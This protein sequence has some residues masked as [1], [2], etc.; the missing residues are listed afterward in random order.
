LFL[1][2]F[3]LEVS[4]E[5][6]TRERE[7]VLAVFEAARGKISNQFFT[8]RTNLHLRKI[9]ILPTRTNFPVAVDFKNGR[10]EIRQRHKDAAQCLREPGSPDAKSRCPVD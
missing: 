4:E 10:M 9:T 6:V 2:Q 1:M 8:S 3:L 7:V 5:G